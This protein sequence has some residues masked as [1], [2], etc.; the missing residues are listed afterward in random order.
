VVAKPR[1]EFLEVSTGGTGWKDDGDHRLRTHRTADGADRGCDGDE[2]SRQ[3]YVSRGRAGIPGFP[4]G[5]GG[6][7]AARIGCGEPALAPV[8]GD[9]RD[10][11]RGEFA[12]DEA[13][14]VPY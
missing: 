4:M 8:P 13:V 14:G 11:Q 2:N 1:L 6:R 3:R 10:D 7:G 12:V 5:D 9:S